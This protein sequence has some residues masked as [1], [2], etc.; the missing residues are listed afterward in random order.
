MLKVGKVGRR[1]GEEVW[2]EIESAVRSRGRRCKGK[3]AT[4]G[5][6]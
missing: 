4:G 6:A 3:V 2:V 1:C 5:V